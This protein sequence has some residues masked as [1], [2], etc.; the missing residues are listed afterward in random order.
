MVPIAEKEA[1]RHQSPIFFGIRQTMYWAKTVK[2]KQDRTE[3]C[4][5]F[6]E[7]MKAYCDPTDF[8]LAAVLKFRTRRQRYFR[9]FRIMKKSSRLQCSFP[10]RG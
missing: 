3:Q 4:R 6:I 5:A 10:G 2:G 1:Q 7:H 9:F 8:G